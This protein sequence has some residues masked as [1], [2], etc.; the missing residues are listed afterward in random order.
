MM[1]SDER[2][3][4][5]ECWHCGEYFVELDRTRYG[6]YRPI[7]KECKLEHYSK[8]NAMKEEYVRLKI[9]LMFDRAI[10]ILEKQPKLRISN[11][12]EAA[13]AVIELARKE[14]SKFGSSHE[15]VAAME[16]IRN[17]V[18][19]KMQYQINRR[20]V[21]ILLPDLRIALEIDG[22]QHKHA[23]KK[24]S[25]RDI[26]IMNVL[27]EE[28][29][30]WEIIRV[31]TGKIESDITDLLPNIKKD[32]IKRQELRK[33]YNGFLPSYYDYHNQAI[34]YKVLEDVNDES[35][36]TLIREGVESDQ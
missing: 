13:D 5:N 15:M 35:K 18:K 9:E 30:G 16:L 3:V 29:G 10:K 36:D 7:H 14:P 22:K 33:R 12:K 23:I 27:N 1:E 8:M 21:D 32:Y 25:Q 6:N 19:V 26:E 31:G 24:D 34:H 17:E 28:K 2:K 20:R 11:Y 4:L